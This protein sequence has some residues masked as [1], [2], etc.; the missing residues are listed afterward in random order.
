ME[1]KL[2]TWTRDI[3]REVRAQFEQAIRDAVSIEKKLELWQSLTR[4]EEAV[5]VFDAKR[6]RKA[7]RKGKGD[8]SR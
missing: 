5:A 1:V 8:S 7:N 3:D 4:T 2:Y 6:I